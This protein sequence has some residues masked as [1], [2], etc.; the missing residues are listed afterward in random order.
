LQDERSLYLV[1]NERLKTEK[2]K[3]VKKEELPSFFTGAVRNT[4][5]KG[6]EH[7]TPQQPLFT[8]ENRRQMAEL[9]R[10]SALGASSNINH[11]QLLSHQDS[12]IG[13]PT[14]P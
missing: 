12:G 9:G 3:I 14:P 13:S 2:K 4:L 5:K 11:G 1:A 7:T 10:R 6:L 8:Q